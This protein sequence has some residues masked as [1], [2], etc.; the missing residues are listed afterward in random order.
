MTVT[1]TTTIQG[2]INGQTISIAFTTTINNVVY[3]LDRKA[4]LAVDKTL[5]SLNE[6]GTP[7]PP[8]I[9][10]AQIAY[11]RFDCY[12]SG[13]CVSNL[14]TTGLASEGLIHQSPGQ[15]FEMY[16]KEAGGIFAISGTATLT[17][18]QDIERL[19]QQPSYYAPADVGLFVAFKPLS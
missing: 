3:I 15:Y 18:L 11:A 16:R 4:T 14:E 2:R 8:Q 7:L 5:D 1:I 6:S 10:N 19:E 13:Q 12:G 17:S 9:D